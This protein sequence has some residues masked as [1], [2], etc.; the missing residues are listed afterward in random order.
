MDRFFEFEK[1]KLFDTW[2]RARNNKYSNPKFEAFHNFFNAFYEKIK[3][4][5]ISLDQLYTIIDNLQSDIQ[6]ETI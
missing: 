1:A 4:K 3:N 6:G 5:N 2:K